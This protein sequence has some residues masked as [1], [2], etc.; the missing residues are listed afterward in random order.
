MEREGRQCLRLFSGCEWR[1]QEEAGGRREQR[2][3]PI[4]ASSVGDWK[5]VAES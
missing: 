3:F 2:A 4:L 5:L 1:R